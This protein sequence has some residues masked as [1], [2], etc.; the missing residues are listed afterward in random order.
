M[1]LITKTATVKVIGHVA[2]MPSILC[3]WN[4]Q[5]Y[6][7]VRVSGTKPAVDTDI[8]ITYK[9]S[10]DSGCPKNASFKL[11]PPPT[12]TSLA[13]AAP[14]VEE[15]EAE[16]G[17]TLTNGESV[18]VKGSRENYQV[19]RARQGEAIFCNCPAW[20]F[21][22]KNPFCRTCKHTEAVC[23]K[24]AEALRVA[25][26]TVALLT[27]PKKTAAPAAPSPANTRR[28]GAAKAITVQ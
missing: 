3:K 1:A 17:I 18:F 23:G 25:V 20:K 19:S 2:N 16:G 28:P 14:T 10:K 27:A 24:Q 4:D 8:T 26:A 6:L 15:W 22:K 9:A 5:E 12:E 11:I 21:Q 13:E 7:R